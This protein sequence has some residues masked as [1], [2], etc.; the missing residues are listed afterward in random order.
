MSSELYQPII[1]AVAA[2]GLAQLVRTQAGEVRVARG[3]MQLCPEGWP[4]LTGFA[5]RGPRKGCLVGVEVKA[6]D[7]KVVRLEGAQ[8]LWL[9]RINDAGGVCIVARTPLEALDRLALQLS[10]PARRVG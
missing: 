9:A 7:T 6:P 3:W 5:L 10:I 8:A 4:D 2:A 1:D